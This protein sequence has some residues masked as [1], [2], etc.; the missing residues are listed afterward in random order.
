MTALVALS[1]AYPCRGGGPVL[2]QVEK[3]IFT[4]RY[5]RHCMACGFCHDACCSHG[6]DVDLENVARIRALPETFK[7][8]VGAPE[9]EWF[10]TAVV[11]DAEFPGGSHVRTAVVDGACVFRSRRGRGCLLH[12]HALAAGFDY[13]D[14]K[15]LVSTLFPVTFE[16]GVLAAAAELADGSLVCAVEGSTLYEG[17]RDELRHY[18]GAGLVAELDSLAAC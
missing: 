7:R 5:F 11:A 14:I 13:H 18:F 10:T 4:L 3:R 1:R 16:R 17:A 12:A 2:R 15:P 8:Q 9:E 6:V